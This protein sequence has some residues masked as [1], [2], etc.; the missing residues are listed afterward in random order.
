MRVIIIIINVPSNAQVTSRRTMETQERK[1]TNG[2]M[3][4]KETV[5]EEKKSL[6]QEKMEKKRKK[7]KKKKKRRRKRQD[8]KL[9]QKKKNETI[10]ERTKTQTRRPKQR[11]KGPKKTEIDQLAC[12]CRQVRSSLI[13]IFNFCGLFN[14]ITLPSKVH[15]HVN[16]VLCA[17]AQTER[18][19]M[20]GTLLPKEP[21][22]HF[23]YW[24]A[25]E[26]YV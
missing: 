17:R 4:A 11:K 5:G 6:K 15:S 2:K 12:F 16:C 14:A 26:K 8:Q 10:R 9:E 24:P 18:G 22:R 20:S 1:S 19:G 7:K 23:Q 21:H 3:E 25:K 13:C